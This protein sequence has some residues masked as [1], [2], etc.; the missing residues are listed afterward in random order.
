MLRSVLWVVYLGGMAASWAY[1]LRGDHERSDALEWRTGWAAGVYWLV[2][3]AEDRMHGEIWQPALWVVFSAA[4]FW[5]WWDRHKKRRKRLAAR[6]AAK[7]QDAGHK[8]VVV[9]VGA[10]S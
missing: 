4:A 7:V 3:A 2:L 5:M 9:P 6:V 1:Y 10:G 8:L